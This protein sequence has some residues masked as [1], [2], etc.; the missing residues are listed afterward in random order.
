MKDNIYCPMA[1]K[2][3][4]VGECVENVD[5]VDSLIVENSSPAEYKQKSEWKEICKKCK[6]HEY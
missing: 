5:I 2:F 3:I 4:G 6:Y 1:D